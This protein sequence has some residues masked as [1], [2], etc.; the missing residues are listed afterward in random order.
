VF[1]EKGALEKSASVPMRNYYLNLYDQYAHFKKTMQT[2]FTPPVQTLYALRQAII[3][4]KQETIP[5]RYARISAC[6]RI[7]MDACARL[8]L[9]NLV[10]EEDQ[11]HIIAAILEPSLPGYDFEAFHDYCRERSFTIYPGKLSDANTFR[12][13]NM[14]DI[15]SEEMERFVAVLEEYLGIAAA[16]TR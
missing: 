3:E 15:R 14:G 1:C 9:T 7:L 12:I 2:R 6:W 8:G 4:A 11:S 5:G 10:A 13:A 16:A